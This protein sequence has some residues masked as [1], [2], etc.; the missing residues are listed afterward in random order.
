MSLIHES[1]RAG[2]TMELVNLGNYRLPMYRRTPE[3]VKEIFE[4]IPNFSCRD[5]DVMIC[6]YPKTG[7]NWLYE[8]VSMIMRGKAERIKESKLAAMLEYLPEEDIQK[9][10]TSPRVLNTHLNYRFL[11]EDLKVKKIKTILIVRNPKDTLVSFFNH[12]NG[13]DLYHYDG[14]WEDWLP[15]S[16]KGKLDNGLYGQY[17]TE[18]EDAIKEGPG[19]PLHIVYYEDLKDFGVCEM[20]KL[21]KFLEV[22]LEADFI[23]DILQLCDFKKMADEKIPK[24]ILKSNLF[25]NNFRL[26]RKGGIGDWKN[27]FTVSQNEMFDDL[28]KKTMEDSDFKFR[29]E[30][31]ASET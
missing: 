11:P 1:D 17:L 12:R 3:Q 4:N 7:T 18:W 24:E 16:L 22:D 29:Y 10:E 25:K 23:K 8:I 30:P 28:W 2:K 20:E 26:Y 6:S 14:K 5:D 27:W 31:I 19:F 9:I 13:I 21:C 15:M